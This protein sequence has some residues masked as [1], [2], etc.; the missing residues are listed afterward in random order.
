MRPGPLRPVALLCA[1][2]ALGAIAASG[3]SAGSGLDRR[4]AESA[5][6]AARAGTPKLQRGL[7]AGEV[8]HDLS[9]RLGAEFGSTI[10]VET[11]DPSRVLT[12]TNT[13]AGP[14]AF[15][16]DDAL[17]PGTIGELSLPTLT[18]VPSGGTANLAI[19]CDP[20]T[21]G[22]SEG[23]LWLA[24]ATSGSSGRIVVNRVPAGS[25]LFR[26]ASAGLPVKPSS[27]ANAKPSLAVGNGIIAATW[28]ETT[29]DGDRVVVSSCDISGE[30][31]DCDLGSNWSTPLRINSSPGSYAMP[32]LAIGAGG[33]LF[34]V[35]W[36]YGT[37]NAVEINRCERAAPEE[38]NCSLEGSWDEEAAVDDLDSFDDEGGGPD[39]LP[40]FCPIIAA[41]GGLMN[42]SPSIEVGP[43]PLFSVY[44][45]YSDLRDNPDP[46]TPTRCTAEGTDKT[47]DSYVAAGTGPGDLPATNS[48]VRLS[49]DL[50]GSLDLNDHFLPAIS[51]DSSTGTVEASF[52][53][54]AAD[55]AGQRTLLI[56]ASSP[57]VGISGF[58][59]TMPA[60]ITDADSRFAGPLST[61]A[62][63]G[64]RQGAASAEGVFRAVWTDSRGQQGRDADLY[65]L[66][67]P[68]Q[69]TITSAPSGTVA[70]AAAD[71]FFST[72][73]PHV[74]CRV[75][76]AAF[77]PCNSPTHI[78][79][80]ANGAHSFSARATDLVG[81]IVEEG[82]PATAGWTV[83]DLTAPITSLDQ[84]PTRK[85]K[86]R[87]PLF[88][89]SANE[90]GAAF[91][92]SYDRVAWKI[93]RTSKRQKVSVGRHIFRVRATD[94]AGNTDASP[95]RWKFKRVRKCTAKRERRGRC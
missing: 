48:G 54:T 73:A 83:Q 68:A 78:L 95:A 22:D 52:Y 23:N 41:P 24:A 36:D 51:V 8:N 63:Y 44:V 81:N 12:A 37:D 19:C 72:P 85:T 60:S 26:S 39:P 20:S 45:S 27:T 64:D 4:G 33:D 53:S 76:G 34:A 43:A 25:T 49:A 91:E 18:S 31:A 9:G 40:R 89:F 32:D 61:G 70:E 15:V 13:S 5:T 92:C 65:G 30:V 28:I 84:R 6:P 7:P 93:C 79:P 90:E 38:E 11:D 75:D 66:T 2:L 71:V 94:V 46:G 74:E 1:L 88:A 86:S 87:N 69:T 35:W 50:D 29:L 21:A 42:P 47:F 14:L 55:P 3:A 58:D 80:L 67:A 82:P 59:W 17:A 16:S 56:Y 77:K 10:A 57:D 62:D